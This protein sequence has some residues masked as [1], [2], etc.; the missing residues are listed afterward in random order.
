MNLLATLAVSLLSAVVAGLLGLGVSLAC[1][2]WYAI[3]SFEG[4]SGYFVGAIT[5]LGM[6]AGLVTGLVVAR[7]ETGDPAPGFLA[8]LLHSSGVLLAVA[9][10][11][12]G[13]LLWMMS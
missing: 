6:L 3:T 5:L 4:K 8:T 9:V 12:A 7:L 1:V 11:Y 2:Q 13:A 10:A